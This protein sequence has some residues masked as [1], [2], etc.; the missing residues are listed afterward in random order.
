MLPKSKFSKIVQKLVLWPP[1]NPPFSAS[2]Y[3]RAA[4]RLAVACLP[5]GLSLIPCSYFYPCAVS[6]AMVA[7]PW[8]LR[9]YRCRY[10]KGSILVYPKKPV[11]CQLYSILLF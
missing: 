7:A 10:E 3:L 8:I 5:L 1:Q 4:Q 6:S 2:M 11:S 9:S